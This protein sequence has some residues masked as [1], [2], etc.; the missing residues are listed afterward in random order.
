MYFTNFFT[1]KKI[2]HSKANIFYTK[3][4]NMFFQHVARITTWSFQQNY[5]E[6]IFTFANYLHQ[7]HNLKVRKPS[8]PLNI[9]L[10]FSLGYEKLV[11][12]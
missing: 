6:M 1:F 8:M 12:N 9:N 11:S 3:C 4:D 7:I 5:G 2:V 10:Q